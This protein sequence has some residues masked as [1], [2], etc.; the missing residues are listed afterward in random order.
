MSTAPLLNGRPNPSYGG[1]NE[2]N[3]QLLKLQAE[4]RY[5]KCWLV[6]TMSI[7]V[8]CL[9][10]AMYRA[11]EIWN[12]FHNGGALFKIGHDVEYPVLLL[13]EPLTKQQLFRPVI[14]RSMFAPYRD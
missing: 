12:L 2:E 13:N 4:F 6:I 11:Y 1:C 9:G 5:W 3:I 14:A 10:L 8:T 7:L